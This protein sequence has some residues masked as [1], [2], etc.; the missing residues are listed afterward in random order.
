MNI[1]ATSPTKKQALVVE[2][3]KIDE[4]F[5]KYTIL[6]ERF[7]KTNPYKFDRK[8]ATKEELV[9]NCGLDGLHCGYIHECAKCRAFALRK[10]AEIIQERIGKYPVLYTYVLIDS[11]EWRPLYKK[12]NRCGFDYIGVPQKDG[13]LLLVCSDYLAYKQHM[14]CEIATKDAIDLLSTEGNLAPTNE[15]GQMVSRRASFG[16]RLTD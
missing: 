16:W 13:S 3:S 7:G 4:Y 15:S 12:I 11:K 14:F 5:Y 10:R 6:N 9:D 2:E 8:A 1:I